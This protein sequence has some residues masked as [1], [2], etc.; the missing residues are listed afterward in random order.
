M[1]CDREDDHYNEDALS[2]R[3]SRPDGQSEVRNLSGADDIEVAEIANTMIAIAAWEEDNAEYCCCGG[4]LLLLLA[5]MEGRNRGKGHH[6]GGAYGY[7]IPHSHQ[8]GEALL[9]SMSGKNSVNVAGEVCL[10]KATT[11]MITENSA[12]KGPIEP[13]ISVSLRRPNQTVTTEA[14]AIR[15][16]PIRG[17]QSRYWL[18]GACA[19]EHDQVAA[20]D[21]NG[22]EQ[23][24][25]SP[26]TLPK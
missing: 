15:H 9:S 4:G 26:A 13:M 11:P 3:S 14:A 12:M 17:S 6:C 21:E 25:T 10:G 22:A 18:S 2:N 23:S 8:V 24:K 1:W 20:A 5:P 19:V 7:A 16:A